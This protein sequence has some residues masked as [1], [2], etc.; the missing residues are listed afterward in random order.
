LN[1]ASKIFCAKSELHQFGAQ[2]SLAAT[3]IED[4]RIA[5]RPA[6]GY[7]F[8]AQFGDDQPGFAVQRAV[9]EQASAATVGEL[10]AARVVRRLMADA[11]RE[12]V[13]EDVAQCVR[14][15]FA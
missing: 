9:V 8:G 2:P 11:V 14:R 3:E 7:A 10:V 5:R 15:G 6:T 13:Q 12:G 4:L 1:S